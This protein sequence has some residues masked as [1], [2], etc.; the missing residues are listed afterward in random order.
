MPRLLLDRERLEAERGRGLWPG[1]V[2]TDYLDRWVAEKPDACALVSWREETGACERLSYRALAARAAGAARVL[3]AC[4]V[5]RGDVVAFQLPNCW[6]FLAA[7][8][9]CVRLG[10]VSNPL[11]PIFRHRELAFM[12]RHGEAR[13]LIA[14][15]RFR[16][17]EHAA[18]AR[19]LGRELPQ[20]RRILLT[21]SAGA[22][23][24][25][26]ALAA[27]LGGPGAGGAQLEP[28]DLMQLMYTSGTTGESKGVLHTSNTLLSAVH[29]YAQR[30]RIGA[31]DVIFMPSPLGHQLGF[32]YG[33]LMSL[34]LGIPLVLTD[35]WQPERALELMR[36]HG[37]TFT[38]GATP[39]LADLAGLRDVERR[40]PPRLR[41]FASSGAPIPPPVVEAARARL[42]VEV[43]TCWGMT[44][45]GS[46]TITPPEGTKVLE[47]DG[48]ALPN[49]EVR[50]LAADGSLAPTGEVGALQVRGSSL[51]VGYLK[52]PELSRLHEGGWFDTGD[53]AR[54]DDEGYIRICGRSKDVIIRG[55][56]NI[57]VIEIESALYRMREV[58]DVAI[59]AMPDARLQE[60]ACA[61]VTL[62]PDCTLTLADVCRHLAAEG[63]S[64]HF[65]P[66]RLE[67]LEQ[68]P[69]TPTGKIQKFVLRERAK[70]FVAEG[71]RALG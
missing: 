36:E 4:G 60:R 50:V 52:R 13:V 32:C 63:Y 61:F 30:M 8:L 31:D 41:L 67:I 42:G 62:H 68:M 12:L 24:F 59:V 37:A 16:G 54:M 48:C 21:D 44:E 66:E 71:G 47:S 22:D 26:A 51:F 28:D 3:A 10:A 38:F 29:Q 9:A 17:F 7:H 25:E 69:R 56:E 65:W 20:L 27:D 23:S 58:G 11:M 49:G 64:K 43:A 33:M 46:V 55:G 39:F 2:V 45:C 6:Q 5:G 40:R 18:L 14:P 57:P 34:M 19:Q 70:A 35:L 15:A 53:L 1:R